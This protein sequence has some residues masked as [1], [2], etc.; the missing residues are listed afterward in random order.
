MAIFS[1]LTGALTRQLA[2]STL[3]LISPTV[4]LMVQAYDFDANPGAQFVS[5]VAGPTTEAVGVTNYARA[6]ASFG[7]ITISGLKAINTWNDTS[8]GV[9]GGASN[10]RLSGAYLFEDTGD[11]ATSP[12]MYAIPFLPQPATDG[13]AFVIRWSAPTARCIQ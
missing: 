8:F 12:L 5:D 2:A 4:L 13:T 9:L 3:D 6:A 1:P 7:P 10:A 11:D